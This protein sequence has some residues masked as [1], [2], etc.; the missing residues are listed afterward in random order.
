MECSESVARGTPQGVPSVGAAQS[1]CLLGKH[2]TGFSQTGNTGQGKAGGNTPPSLL[3]GTAE[4]EEMLSWPASHFY[5]R[6]KG[7][8]MGSFL[9]QVCPGVGMSWATQ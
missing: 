2:W 6:A 9:G 8:R 5:L 1:L 7:S 3:F 4:T